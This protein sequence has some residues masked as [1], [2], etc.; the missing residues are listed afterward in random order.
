MSTEMTWHR[1]LPVLI[2]TYR[3]TL[4]LKA[5][6]TLCAE[7][8][9]A[10]QDGPDAVVVLAD[11]REFEGFPDAG[12]MDALDNVLHHDTVCGL[13]IVTSDVLFNRLRGLVADDAGRRYAVY[14]FGAMDS[15]VEAARQMLH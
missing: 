5:Y 11:M 8:A 7:R 4:T 15:A 9:Q 1:E 14:I 6:R 3:G 10:L 12:E 13:V 2:V